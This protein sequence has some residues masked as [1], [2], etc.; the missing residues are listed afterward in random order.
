MA[1]ICSPGMQNGKIKQPGLVTAIDQQQMLEPFNFPGHSTGAHLVVTNVQQA[2]REVR[3]PALQ[4]LMTGQILVL[5]P[6][7]QTKTVNERSQSQ[8]WLQSLIDSSHKQRP[9]SDKTHTFLIAVIKFPSFYKQNGNFYPCECIGY[10]DNTTCK[11]RLLSPCWWRRCDF[12]SAVQHLSVK[13][14]HIRE[15]TI[16]WAP[17]RL[18]VSDYASRFLH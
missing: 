2:G 11:T 15:H 16:H 1:L 9:N 14:V 7:N 4:G 8:Q 13:C 17:L 5:N 12:P 3:E 6:L 10:E 18:L